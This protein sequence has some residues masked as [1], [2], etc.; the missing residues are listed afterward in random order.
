M[1]KLHRDLRNKEFWY[2]DILLVCNR[3]PDFER[4]EVD[5]T[6]KLSRNITLKTPFVSSPMDTVTGSQMAIMMALMG[7][8]GVI[9]YNYETIDEQM[10]E[11]EKVKRFEAAF[12]KKPV[13]LSPKNKVEDVYQI[14]QKFGFYSVPITED[15][16]INS[17]LVGIITHRDVRYLETKKEMKIP[18]SKIMTPREKLITA[19]KE[20]TLDKNDIRAANKIIRKYN[21][22]TLPIV[23]K[24]FRIVALV[25]DSDL[26][27]N[28]TYPLATKDENK[29]L[30]VLVAVESRLVLAK[31]RI[32]RAVEAGADGIVL[33]AS[34]VF[35][36]QLEIARFAKKHFPRLE[37]I[38]GNVDSG[39]MVEEVMK[40]ANSIVD[41]LRVGIGPGAAC[42][43]QEYLGIGRAQGSAVWDC[44]QAAKKLAKKSGFKIPIIADGGIR[45]PS[46]IIK[47]LALGAETVMMGGL[48]AGLEESPGEAEFDEEKGYLVKKY[49]GMGS[50][51]AMEK[52][53]AFRYGIEKMEIKVPEGKVTKVGYKGSGYIFIHKLIAAVKQGMQKLGTRN[54]STLQK[55]A[56]IIP[57]SLS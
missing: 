44:S 41:G 2:R 27:K 29:Q 12:V 35:K 36:E 26:R 16:T 54:L 46:D 17:K 6:T 8:I 40:N 57:N 53:G 5:L 34:V 19:P 38:L 33:D 52:R 50:L 48:L 39:K 20:K 14:A 56:E 18:L 24:N 1:A 43:T 51:E 23:D 3:L 28:E 13:V 47:A 7:A 4:D 42:I 21:L 10:E 55:I 11:V 32:K 25:T 30:K 49:R 45:K 15:G 22:D 9:H 37:V 31:E